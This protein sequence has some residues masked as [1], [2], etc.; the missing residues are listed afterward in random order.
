MRTAIV[1][2]IASAL[3]VCAIFLAAGA[4]DDEPRGEPARTS[5]TSQPAVPSVRDVYRRTRPAVVLIDHRPPGVRP[6]TGPPRRDDGIAT[7][8]GFVIDRE[9]HVVTNQHIVAGRGTTTV[10]FE[11]TTTP[12]ARGSSGATRRRIWRS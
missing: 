3:A 12:F 10:Q 4:F 5:T 6:R 7:G 1:S 2:G 9:G 8:S 11:A